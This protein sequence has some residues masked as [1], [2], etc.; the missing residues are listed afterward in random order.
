MT[1]KDYNSIVK[2]IASVS[3]KIAF[4]L[5]FY[6]YV[7]ADLSIIRDKYEIVKQL[8]E[9]TFSFVYLAK[10]MR[11]GKPVSIKKIKNDKTFFDQSLS[12][13]YIL[14]YLKKSGNPTKNNFLDFQEAFYFNV[15]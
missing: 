6:I 9:S 3:K 5:K 15:D 7:D 8:K 1:F 4:N 2:K 14:D 11:S 13:I 12:E 10:N